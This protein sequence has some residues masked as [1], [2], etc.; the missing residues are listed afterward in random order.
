M[1]L[2]RVGTV[3]RGIV[4]QRFHYCQTYNG[5]YSQN[6]SHT[7]RLGQL[8]PFSF[9]TAI[10]HSRMTHR[11]TVSPE[12]RFLMTSDAPVSERNELMDK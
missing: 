1:P 3:G 10:P 9:S 11:P 12:K 4:Q 8:R 7:V 2:R 6:P 5:R